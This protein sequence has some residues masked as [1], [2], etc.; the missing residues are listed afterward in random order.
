MS[1]PSISAAKN[2]AWRTGAVAALLLAA[3]AAH[4]QPAP[5]VAG[6]TGT[7]NGDTLRYPYVAAF[8]RS[9][10][11]DR[12]YFCAG[13][14]IAPRWILTAAHCFHNP[15]GARITNRDLAAEVGA[16][17]LGEVPIE[18]QV[19]IARI[20]VHPDYDRESQDNDIALIELAEEA[21]PLI[22]EVATPRA[23]ADSGP[24]TVLGFGSFYEGRLAASAVSRSGAPAAQLS[25]RLRQAVVRLVDPATCAA[26][27]GAAGP[28]TGAHQMCAGAG[29]DATCVGDSGSPLIVEGPDRTDRVA[30]IVSLGSGCA[31]DRPVTVYTRVSAYAGWIAAT[32]RG[33]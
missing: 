21:G 15:R 32:M 10:G 14:L 16:N 3:G 30:G 29:S 25:D 24:A 2:R 13:A 22:A 6:A 27:L 31:A 17:W 26:R 28:A 18:A 23:T 12:V 4:A 1:C 20:V 9:S 5:R 7:R 11:G 19:A 33:R 8:S